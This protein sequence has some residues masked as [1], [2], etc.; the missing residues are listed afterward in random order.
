MARQPRIFRYFCPKCGV[1]NTATCRHCKTIYHFD[2]V[3]APDEKWVIQRVRF[4]ERMWQRIVVRAK[5]TPGVNGPA[6]LIR[7]A[8]AEV[9]AMP[10]VRLISS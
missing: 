2:T 10:P 7:L 1:Q 3:K 8:C 9:L 6:E 5:V 4:P